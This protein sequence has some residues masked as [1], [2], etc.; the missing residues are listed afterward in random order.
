MDL[1]VER[2]FPIWNVLQES[3]L[4]KIV[5]IQLTKSIPNPNY[6]RICNKKQWLTESNAFSLSTVTR[7][8]SSVSEF[9]ISK[10]S[11]TTLPLLIINQF[12]TYAVWFEEIRKGNTFFILAERTLLIIFVSVLSSDIGLQFLMNL[13]SLSFFPT[14]YFTTC[15][16]ELLNSWFRNALWI[17]AKKRVFDFISKAFI[18][19]F[20]E[21]IISRWFIVFHRL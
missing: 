2:L 11:E 7:K 1:L 20:R 16:W 17:E 15:F 12:L 19:F 10:I 4:F 13:L 14:F 6:R 5:L 18:Q 9:D 21:S 3:W 8:P